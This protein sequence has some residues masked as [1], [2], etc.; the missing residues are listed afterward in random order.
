MPLR[1]PL[2]Q[3]LPSQATP[4]CPAIL[5]AWIVDPTGQ[6]TS[7]GEQIITLSSSENLLVT[8]QSSLITTISGIHRLVYG[9]YGPED[10]L[11]CS[12][13]EAFDVGDA[14]LMGLST[15]KRDY[16][17]NTEPVIVT[18]SLF[19]SVG[20]ELQLELDGALVKTETISLN[21]FTTY[22]TELQNITPGPHTLKA[23]LT[24]GGIKSTKETSFTYALAFMP[25]PQISVSPAY[26][27]FGS[28]NLGSASTQT[29]TLSST[30]NADLVIGAI[31]LSGTNQGEFSIQN[32]SCAGRTIGSSGNCTLDV[33]FSPNSLGLKSASLFIPS[34]ATEMPTLYLPLEGTGITNLSVSIN[35]DASGRV[36]GTGIDCPGDCTESFST[37][38]ASIQLTA[39]PTE[40]YQFTNWTGD[41]N[42]PEN[43][44]TIAMA[45]HKNVTAN[46]AINPYT[47]NVTVNLGG[48]ITPSGLVAVNPGASQT[49]IITPNPGYYIVDVRVDGVSVGAVTTYTLTN[50]TSN[51]TIEAIFAIAQYTLTASAGANGVIF[52]SGTITV[53]YG[54]SQSFTITPDAG[55][56]VADVKV[57]GASVGAV[58]SFT[59]D[60]VTSHHTIEASFDLDTTATWAKTYGGQGYDVALSAR[61]T[62]DGGYIVAGQSW[63]FNPLFSNAWIIKL[64]ANGNTQW[65]KRYG[66]SLNDVSYS[67]E[68]TQDGGYIMAGETNAV[69]PFLGLFW[70]VKINANGEVQWQK[71]YN[72]GWAHSIQQT[73]EGGYVATGMNMGK[74]WIVKLDANGS[75]QW[76]KKYAGI[77]G[78]MAQSV[79][80]TSEGGYIVA[81]MMKGEVWVLKLNSA[82]QTQWQK[83][84]GNSSV[85]A[86]FSIQQTQ[87]GGYILA[88]V[89][90]TFGAGLTDIWIVKLDP[91]GE[92]E[93]QKTYGGSG[94]DLAHAIQQTQDGGYVVAGWTGSFGAGD[95]DAWVL[96]LDAT[97]EI[98]WQKTYGGSG[99]ELAHSIEQTQD[100][101]YVVAGWTDSFGAG[102]MDMWILKLDANGNMSGCPGGLIG[103]TSVVPYSTTATMSQCNV[104]G[105][106]TSVSPKQGNT[107]VNG[108]N[109]TPG[110]V[111][112]D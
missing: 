60:N 76:Q 50:I 62:G 75:I 46:F 109:I 18:A 30:G 35:P 31:A 53:N 3:P 90:L 25:K 26:L 85:D 14:V 77:L 27:D 40:G 102:N 6:Y 73:S 9:I 16:P 94:L 44:V 48:H 51:H 58:T 61:Q 82:G 65:Q 91:N 88:S 56:H 34:N 105:Q 83:T 49:F 15:D 97:G 22:T 63:S 41:I 57:D 19:G 43:P 101:G 92:I 8:H 33:L 12:G 96:K 59:F 81:G 23:T 108:T 29:I 79:Q 95:K 32:D 5:K 17:T 21:G 10:L 78:D 52:P 7:V 38:G 42:S 106:T 2:P 112:G 98:E 72:Q 20:A 45:T 47:I 4:L 69:L 87:E 1:I 104:T 86:S 74:P 68:Q 36:T 64:D 70:A 28:I 37:E 93:W 99:F 55:C 110:G 11:L 13:S 54:A 84:Y 100:G 71:T 80:Q 24:A 66:G 107:S 39:T 67:I 89:S 111:C 103:A